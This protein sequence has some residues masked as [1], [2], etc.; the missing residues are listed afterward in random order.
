MLHKE[1]SSS[2]ELFVEVLTHV[3]KPANAETVEAGDDPE[4]VARRARI[5]WQLLDSWRRVPGADGH[6]AVDGAV[7]CVW[8]HRARVLAA[9]VDRAAVADD[10]IGKVL[11]HAPA[12]PDGAWPHRGVRQALEEF[13]TEELNRGLVCERH[14]MRGVFSR[15]LREGGTKERALAAEA[16]GWAAAVADRWPRTA[17]LLEEV[18]AMWERY[19]AWVDRRRDLDDLI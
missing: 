8:V 5:S 13:D 12:D 4:V 9:A 11:A 1:L 18:A 2:P 15:G 19:A 16:R 17:A 7:L 3:F 10:R 14:N 6:G